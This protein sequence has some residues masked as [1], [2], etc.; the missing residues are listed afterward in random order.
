MRLKRTFASLALGMALAVSVVAPVT[1]SAVSNASNSSTTSNASSNASGASK[2]VDKPLEVVETSNYTAKRNT[3]ALKTFNP[4][5]MTID[6]EYE[7]AFYT[8]GALYITAG[9][10][11]SDPVTYRNIPYHAKAMP[12]TADHIVWNIPLK[13]GLH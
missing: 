11:D 4:H 3:G 13:D 8:G 7:M 5:R 9:D 12:E 10:P 1:A 6:T 2:I